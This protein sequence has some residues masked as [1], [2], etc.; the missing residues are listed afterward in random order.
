MRRIDRLAAHHR[1]PAYDALAL[2]FCLSA[3]DLPTADCHLG[4]P[5]DRFGLADGLFAVFVERAVLAGQLVTRVLYQFPAALI[6][7]L[8]PVDKVLPSGNQVIRSLFAL[9]E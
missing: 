7:V 2:S 3:C 4:A 8:A 5:K 1:T 9:A 6:Q